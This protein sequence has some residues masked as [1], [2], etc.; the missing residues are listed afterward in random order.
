MK[1][2][3]AMI[4][5]CVIVAAL[6]AVP[7]AQADPDCDIE[8]ESICVS[9]GEYNEW[10]GNSCIF[11]DAFTS[12]VFVGIDASCATGGV[13]CVENICVGFNNNLEQCWTEWSRDL[14]VHV[15]FNLDYCFG[16][17]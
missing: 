2:A 12:P 7:V 4:G 9:F 3:K 11:I 6:A 8:T 15:E 16:I 10:W 13:Q 17:N 14:E 1:A 5:I